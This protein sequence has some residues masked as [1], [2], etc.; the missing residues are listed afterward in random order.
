MTLL[1]QQKPVVSPEIISLFH[2][3]YFTISETISLRERT[4]RFRM[5]KINYYSDGDRAVG[6]VRSRKYKS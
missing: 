6:R 4:R 5:A 3:Y 2:H 1:Q